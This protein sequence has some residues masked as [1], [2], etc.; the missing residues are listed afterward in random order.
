MC[1]LGVSR[2]SEMSYRVWIAP[3]HDG[4]FWEPWQAGESTCGVDVRSVLRGGANQNV[5]DALTL[6]SMLI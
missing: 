6:M 4:V 3:F 1:L 5:V 2:A